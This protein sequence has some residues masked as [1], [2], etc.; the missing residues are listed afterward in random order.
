M[1]K[2]IIIGISVALLIIASLLFWLHSRS[3]SDTKIGQRVAGTWTRARGGPLVVNPD[4]SWAI[5]SLGDSPTNSYAG[6][7]QI[8]GGVLSMTITNGLVEGGHSPV[9]GIIGYKI[10]RVDDHQL[11]YKDINEGRGTLLHTN[12]R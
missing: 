3:P 7:W 4:G 9:G 12:S 2:I 8:K 11:V 5:K 10:I 1:K 6:T